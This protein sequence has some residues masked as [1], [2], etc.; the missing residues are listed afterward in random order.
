M[1]WQRYALDIYIY[2]WPVYVPILNGL[3]TPIRMHADMERLFSL[4][5]CFLWFEFGKF[6]Y[7]LMQFIAFAAMFLMD[8]N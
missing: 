3:E 5:Q 2:N 8:G 1:R 4:E 7:L 6:M